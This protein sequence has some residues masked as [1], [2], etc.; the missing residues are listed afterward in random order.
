MVTC[1]EFGGGVCVLCVV[2]KAVASP[3]KYC[4]HTKLDGF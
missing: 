1:G 2:F 3:V 4:S